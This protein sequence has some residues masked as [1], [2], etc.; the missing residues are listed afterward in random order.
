[1]FIGLRTLASTVLHV[2][3][4]P[5]QSPVARSKSIPPC[6]LYHTT[7]ASQL[8]LGH[9]YMPLWH[10]NIGCPT[11][12]AGGSGRPIYGLSAEVPPCCGCSYSGVMSTWVSPREK[13]PLSPSPHQLFNLFVEVTKAMAFQEYCHCFFFKK[14]VKG[15]GAWVAQS[16]E[17]LTSAQV[18][19]SR[20]VGLGPTSSSELTAQSLESA[21]DSVSF[22]LSAPPLLALSLSV[23]QK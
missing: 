5:L 14:P 2:H 19:I 7:K 17:C 12:G 1:M 6:P 9:T 16:V 20:F 8:A 10:R 23:S 18:M 22:S 15:W 21:S 4:W 3:L 11:M 13:L